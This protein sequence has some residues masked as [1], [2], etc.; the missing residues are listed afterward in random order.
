MKIENTSSSQ[1]ISLITMFILGTTIIVGGDPNAMEDIWISILLSIVMA[2]VVVL[3][4]G[5]IYKYFPGVGLFDI[6]P[7]VYGEFLGKA[8]VLFYTLYFLYLSSLAMRNVTAY[9]QVVSFP[10]TPQYV[11]AIFIGLLCVYAIDG[12]FSVIATWSKMILPVIILMTLSTFIL[13]IPQFNYDYIRPVLY[14]G[15]EP[16]IKGAY[17]MLIFPFTE[18]VIFMVFYNYIG[19]KKNTNKIYI[20]SIL[21]GGLLFLIIIFRNILLLGFPNLSNMYFKSHYATSIIKIDNFVQRME[22]LVSLN[23]FLT[24]FIKIVIPIYA[25][26]IGVFKL[27]HFKNFKIVP[28]IISTITVILSITLFTSTMDMMKEVEIY[29]YYIIPFHF[30]IPFLTLIIGG[31]K[32]KQ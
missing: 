4:Y 17:T 16:V 5:R 12:G 10:E 27:F 22:S 31:I 26:S 1:V 3:V 30:I 9:V 6:L 11:T 21:M 18:T 24:S 32:K 14:N 8:F 19:D 25:S 13:G 20:S 15:W 28:P 2:I 23:L 7:K 29:K